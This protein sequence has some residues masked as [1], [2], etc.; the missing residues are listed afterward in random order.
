M[1]APLL[2]RLT[3]GHLRTS[4]FYRIYRD[5]SGQEKWQGLF[6][7]APLNFA[8]GVKV[9]LLAS[10]FMHAEIAFTG[11]YERSLS[12][13]VVELGATG[14]TFV[15]VGANIGYFSLLWAASL[16]GNRVHAFEASPRSLPLLSQNVHSNNLSDRIIIYDCALGRDTGSAA[17][18]L[19]PE[20][21]SGWGGLSLDPS[22]DNIV[23]V[24]VKR[25]DDIIGDAHI[26]LLKIDVEGAD[27]WVL[28]GAKKLLRAKHIKRIWFEQ[29]AVRMKKL[30]IAEHAAQS[31]L[32]SLGYS[33][34][35]VSDA[36]QGTVDWMAIP[37]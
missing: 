18:D 35:P 15:D 2:L 21:V 19:G 5:Q 14:G 12:R 27:T 8:P 30:G 6:Q 23:H 36:S 10:D 20:G 22:G 7:S 34:R 26:D 37:T 24:P 13:L 9:S 29:N 17:F 31:F 1:K 11:E 25:L 4:M 28:M 16:T 3:S 32:R 33:A